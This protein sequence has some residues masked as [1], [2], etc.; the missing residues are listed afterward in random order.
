MDIVRHERGAAWTRCWASA[1]RRSASATGASRRSVAPA[2]RDR[3]PEVTVPHQRGRR[4]SSRREGLIATP[5]A[6]D[7]TC[8]YRPAARAGGAGGRHHDVRRDELLRRLRPRDQPARQLRPPA[9]RLAAVPLNLLPIARGARPNAG[10]LE[11]LLE[12]GGGGV[13]DP[14]G[15]RRLPGV[16]DA[17]AAPPPTATTCRWRCTPT[18]WASPPRWRRPLAA[19]AGRAVH[20]YHVEGCGGGAREPA[21]AGLAPATCCPPRRR[22][23]F[24][25]A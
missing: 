21:G 3:R 13:Q 17:V 11:A 9:R 16:V 22:R 2:T 25:S 20:A 7:S 19:I 4:A 24:P 15:R 14:R 18:G 10:F 5:G 23:R 1:R 8:T 12:M 6:I